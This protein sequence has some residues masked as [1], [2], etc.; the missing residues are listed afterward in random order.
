MKHS[1]PHPFSLLAA[2]ALA[3]CGG[4]SQPALNLTAKVS[5]SA[6]D[7]K[8]A[9][10][11]MATL[12]STCH[13]TSGKGDGAAGAALNP[14]PRNWTDAAWQKT[15]TDD[16]LYKVIKDGGAA[17]GLSPL[18]APNANY[19]SRPGVLAALVELVRGYAPK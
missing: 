6:E 5:I 19:G 3:S 15:V 10:A 13:G 8:L 9:K 7:R 11:E 14:K 2:L 18:M 12:C 1:S 17:V 16:H 4:D